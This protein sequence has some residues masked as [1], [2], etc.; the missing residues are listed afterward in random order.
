MLEVSGLKVFSV[1]PGM[2]DLPRQPTGKQ[3]QQ[4]SLGPRKVISL[5]LLCWSGLCGKGYSTYRERGPSLGPSLTTLEILHKGQMF[6][7]S[8]QTACVCL[9]RK[10]SSR[11]PA[12]PRGHFSPGSAGTGPD[13]GQRALP[14]PLL[15]ALGRPEFS[16]PQ[17]WSPRAW[18]RLA[19]PKQ[20]TTPTVRACHA[21]E[22]MGEGQLPVDAEYFQRKG[23]VF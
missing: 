1:P 13:A 2:I 6:P 20:G 5:A 8:Q 21:P 22:M 12:R 23:T 19:S 16:K 9:K 18:G 11:P 15:M 3:A 10:M 17:A 14:L 7:E 4:I